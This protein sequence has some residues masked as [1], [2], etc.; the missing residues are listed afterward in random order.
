MYVRL[1]FVQ[2]YPELSD[3]FLV[4]LISGNIMYC[5]S[6]EKM[7]LVLLVVIMLV[8]QVRK[9]KQIPSSL[10][11]GYQETKIAAFL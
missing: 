1:I 7:C 6:K 9:M 3:N 8:L 2:V 5:C 4:I 10:L 11:N